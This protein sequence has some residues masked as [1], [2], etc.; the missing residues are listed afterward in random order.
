MADEGSDDETRPLLSA[1]P[2]PDAREETSPVPYALLK[3]TIAI[4]GVFLVNA[5]TSLV[6]ATYPAIASEFRNLSEGPWM[7]TGYTLGFSVALPAYGATS[8]A[9]GRKVPLLVAYCLFSLGCV[10]SGIAASLQQ[11]IV[12]R[13]I[14]GLGA[15]GVTTLAAVVITD[16]AP[17]SK[18]A[19]LRSYINVAAVVGRATGGPIGGLLIDSIGWRWPFFAEL[20]IVLVCFVLAVSQSLP[21]PEFLE[22]G[23]KKRELDLLGLLI[24]ALMLSFL[25]SLVDLGGRGTAMGSPTTI[26]LLLL[27]AV[28]AVGFGLVEVF[29]AKQPILSPSLLRQAG[30]AS[31]YLL[32]ILLLCAQFSIVSNIA[33]YFARTENASNLVA[34]LHVLPTSFGN[35]IGALGGGKW[36]SRTKRYKKIS[37]AAVS[38][39][40]I[41]FI[42]IMLRWRGRINV[43]ESLLYVFSASLGVG[44][45]NSSQFIGLAASIEKPQLATAVSLFYLSQQMGLMIGASGSAALLRT[46]FRNALVKNL[47]HSADG[48]QHRYFQMVD[49]HFSFSAHKQIIKGILNDT[50]FALRLPQGLQAVA[51]SSYLHGFLYVSSKDLA[52]FP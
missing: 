50:K 34:A 30:V 17:L 35:A 21:Q 49:A 32:Q 33:I 15:A 12:G 39:C 9:L 29:W 16:I 13:F 41:S 48:K 4:I 45:L 31:C 24:F 28:S 1:P 36:I 22:G 52:R 7:L 23:R 14:S 5:D 25:L 20:S 8:D 51:L 18:V 44:M 47:G 43:W 11:L 27:F 40:I 6:V 38:L 37:I 26:S 2:S 19:I 46:S 42:A 10:L 3:F